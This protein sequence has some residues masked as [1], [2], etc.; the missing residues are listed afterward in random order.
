MRLYGLDNTMS[1]NTCARNRST[2]TSKLLWGS[3]MRQWCLCCWSSALKLT[4]KT[5]GCTAICS[6]RQFTSLQRQARPV[7]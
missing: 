2:I 4:Q 1:S 7:W 3:A 5:T 6:S